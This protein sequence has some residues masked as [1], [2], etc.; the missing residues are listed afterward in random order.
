[1][2]LTSAIFLSLSVSQV[3]PKRE[4][5]GAWIA[6]VQN[7]DWPV[8]VGTSVRSTQVSELNTLLDSLQR[9]GVNAVV[10]QVRPSCDAFYKSS[11][12]P[13]SQW[14]TGAQGVGPT[15]SSYDPLQEA[16][17][18]AHL[19][20]M[21]IHAWFN[22]YR[23]VINTS[24]SSIA[25]S[26]VS[27]THPEWVLT[28][29]TLKMLDPGLP[30]VRSYVTNV[31]M[32]VIRRYDIDGVH[33]D[34][35]FYPYSGISTEDSASY[36]NYGGSQPIGD[37]RRGNVNTLIHMVSDSIKA[38]KNRVK[39]GISPFGIWKS[40]T[41]P[42]V[43]G[44]SAYSAIYCDA[45]TWLQEGWIDYLT[46]QL[47][48]VIGG[49]QDY[50]KLMPWWGTN[51]YSRHIYP[52]QATYHVS[53]VNW[54]IAEIVN[55]IK[56]NRTNAAQGGTVLGSVHF[57]AKYFRSNTKTL[58]DSLRKTVYSN[59]TTDPIPKA[60]AFLPTMAWKDSVPPNTPDSLSIASLSFANAVLKW[61]T[62]AV[63]RDSEGISQY[64]L[65]RSFSFPIDTNDVRNIFKITKSLNASVERPLTGGQVYYYAVTAIDRQN[66]ESPLSNIIGL[67]T[68][69]VA[70]QPEQPRAFALHQNFPNPFNP[71]T[72]ISYQLSG[73]SYVSLKVYDVL[74]REVRVLIEG[75]E[76]SGYH[77]VQF[78][79]SGLS[80]GV[81][82]YRLVAGGRVE[83]KSMQLI[84]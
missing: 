17:N 36:A 32:D 4:F 43:N 58:N 53:D 54:P 11:I 27:V 67:S 13:W 28:F 15:D 7:I 70:D 45:I 29:G 51:S 34:D 61:K 31:I 37:W 22:P 1:M 39:F 49:P 18:A 23:A 10:F 21:E 2:F 5:R 38:V 52:G 56:L 63:S 25:N 35:Y 83:T 33:F 14:L 74:G 72:A 47:Y 77:R 64:V 79:G 62:P 16:V 48:W 3:P 6:T 57:S 9:L 78:D 82:F 40:G 19:R 50:S 71:T 66:N 26:H 20:S 80:S 68:T 24:S 59:F 75:I 60:F 69:G 41:P 55:Q 30:A 84:K 73:I 76:E 12:E 46:P 42:G 65:Y 8:T 81:Y 44:L